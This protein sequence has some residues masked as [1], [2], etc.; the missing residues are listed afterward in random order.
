[1][2]T[3]SGVQPPVHSETP[4]ASLGYCLNRVLILPR[5]ATAQRE[6]AIP[7]QLPAVVQLRGASLALS[8]NR[9]GPEADSTVV[10]LDS[11]NSRGASTQRCSCASDTPFRSRLQATYFPE[12]TERPE[13]GS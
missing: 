10:A 4:R 9:N 1:M 6:P 7:Y 2:G 8:G 12:S 13:M 11:P 3:R 5:L